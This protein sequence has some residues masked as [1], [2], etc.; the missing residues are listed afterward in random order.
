MKNCKSCLACR[1]PI[2]ASTKFEVKRIFEETKI[3][4]VVETSDEKAL[5]KMIQQ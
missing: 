4:F 2:V 1:K 3:G 5:A